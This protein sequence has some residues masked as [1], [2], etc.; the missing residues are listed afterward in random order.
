M[1]GIGKQ[2]LNSHVF[3]I[4]YSLHIVPANRNTENILKF[5]IQYYLLMIR[6]NNIF[7]QIYKLAHGKH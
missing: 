6:W 7:D 3:Q 1:T 4:Q 2:R 5:I